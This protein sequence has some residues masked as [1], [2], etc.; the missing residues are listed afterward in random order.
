MTRAGALGCAILA[1]L[2]TVS[3]R[4]DD[5]QPPAL[6]QR[7]LQSQKA[8]RLLNPSVDLRDSEATPPR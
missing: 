2:S 5:A 6:L 1:L 4:A 8:W 7:V 3:L